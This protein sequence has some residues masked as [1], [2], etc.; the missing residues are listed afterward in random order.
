MGGTSDKSELDEYGV[1]VKNNVHLG[2][3]KK[4]EK[5]PPS[6]H[7]AAAVDDNDFLENAMISKTIANEISKLDDIPLQQMTPL[8]TDNLGSFLEQS[9]QSDLLPP[10]GIN[11]AQDDTNPASLV[12]DT[13][14][15]SI[16]D[17][18]DGEI[19]LASFMS[20]TP[21]G[22]VDLSAFMDSFPSSAT[23]QGIADGDVDL[24]A[25]M[26]SS[27]ASS[28][29]GEVDLSAFMGS[30]PTS[31]V[32][33]DVDLS[34]FLGGGNGDVDLSSFMGD[35]S[36]STPKEEQ[37]QFQDEQPLDL[38]LVFEESP[39]E[40]QDENA[41]TPAVSTAD[42]TNSRLDDYQ[43]LLGGF[44]QDMPQI[45]PQVESSAAS[46]GEE[47]ID[48]SAFGFDDSPDAL[49]SAGDAPK[50]KKAETVIDY[51]MNVDIEEEEESEK[52]KV[53]AQDDGAS[54]DDDE[55]KVDISQDSETPE[56][57]N[58]EADFSSPDDSFDLDAIFSNIEDESGNMVSFFLDENS[59]KKKTSNDVPTEMPKRNDSQTASATP[60]SKEEPKEDHLPDMIATAAFLQATAEAA[61]ALE[62]GEKDKE[63]L[64]IDET[65]S[66]SPV[67]KAET[68]DHP[69]VDMAEI[70]KPE[71]LNLAEDNLTSTQN[72]TEESPIT[73]EA[74]DLTPT[75]QSTQ[76]SVSPVQPIQSMEDEGFAEGKDFLKEAGLLDDD[77]EDAA[78]TKDEATAGS[79][80]LAEEEPTIGLDD[81]QKI[82][83]EEIPTENADL[84]DIITE[85]NQETSPVESIEPIGPVEIDEV[86]ETLQEEETEYEIPSLDAKELESLEALD[87]AVEDET[88]ET[89][90][91][92]GAQ[93]IEPPTEMIEKAEAADDSENEE[94][95]TEAQKE[96][97]QGIT[98]ND[99]ADKILPAKTLTEVAAQERPLTLQAD[100]LASF[101]EPVPVLSEAALDMA[102][103]SAHEE[104]DDTAEPTV[105]QFNEEEKIHLDTED[106][107]ELLQESKEKSESDNEVPRG[108]V[109]EPVLGEREGRELVTEEKTIEGSEQ[110]IENDEVET[111][112]DEEKKKADELDV[113]A[114][115]DKGPDYDMTGVTVTLD[116]LEKMEEI[117]I[118]E[119]EIPS[120]LPQETSS[121]EEMQEDTEKQM[122]SVFV[123]N[124]TTSSGEIEEVGAEEEEVEQK[125]KESEN[126]AIL[127]KIAQELESLKAEISGLRDEFEQL[128]KSG[129]PA[130]TPQEVES[131]PQEEGG[132]FNDDDGDDTIALSGD[133]LSNIL[134]TAEFTSQDAESL[135]KEET[136]A[137]EAPQ[138]AAES[139]TG[140]VETRDESETKSQVEE[141]AETEQPVVETA[142]EQQVPSDA[143]QD[144]VTQK[145]EV[146]PI[147]QQV[148]ETP[149]QKT[150]E[151]TTEVPESE[152]TAEEVT[153]E[154]TTEEESATQEGA[155]G[156][157]ESEAQ[158]EALTEQKADVTPQGEPAEQSIQETQ[159]IE[160]S[161]AGTA[162]ETETKQIEPEIAQETQE[163]AV[164]ATTEV[165][166]QQPP[167]PAAE[168]ENQISDVAQEASEAQVSEPT[169]EAAPEEIDKT[170][171]TEKTEKTGETV[172]TQT[173]ED[174]SSET[175]QAEPAEKESCDTTQEPNEQIAEATEA[176]KE[177]PV[178]AE[179]QEQTTEAEGESSDVE[180]ATAE[181]LVVE[182]KAEGEAQESA[183]DPSQAGEPSESDKLAEPAGEPDKQEE[184]IQETAEAVAQETTPEVQ[185]EQDAGQQDEGS[186]EKTSV[187]SE[188]DIP[189]PTLESLN[190]P[191]LSETYELSEEET[192]PLTE[193]NIE[194]LKSDVPE[195][196]DEDEDEENIETGISE[197]PV[198][199]FSNWGAKTEIVEEPVSE[200][201]VDSAAAAEA[202]EEISL[203]KPQSE[204]DVEVTKTDEAKSE[205]DVKEEVSDK[206]VV[207]QQQ[208]TSK[209]ENITA[210]LM[211][212]IK[213]VLTYM[214]RLLENLPEEKIEEFARSEQFETYKKLFVELGLA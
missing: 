146:E 113:S 71:S 151:E 203:P 12:K 143:L 138:Q 82:E 53:K 37:A 206:P 163:T 211:A 136:A 58:Q 142:S 176:V 66:V 197:Q 57:K 195:E 174:V 191:T 131:A 52:Q 42:D 21:D 62:K 144:D 184:P 38:D 67:G 133:E 22:D 178:T 148:Q 162:A 194:Y 28:P 124:E 44:A 171:E 122:Y 106:V 10:S 97:I 33:G 56:Q 25:F 204:A 115:I 86:D 84:A 210:D 155:E 185:N 123:C 154:A 36:I 128:K 187:I 85:E 125:G 156:V 20:D 198:D 116:D 11:G 27:P 135:E 141:A 72:A 64:K 108:E 54:D 129:V 63:T 75:L 134:S 32:D 24:S 61:N 6:L 50:E 153:P 166:T 95:K 213:A 2:A 145:G 117:P 16:Q 109:G 76:T 90:E 81:L 179:T 180:N 18:P 177:E 105:P 149:V 1:W 208:V 157:A 101:H 87:L 207:A 201:N 3:N 200:P 13:A 147:E 5:L 182:T 78:L 119:P 92:S 126:V 43:S 164:E 100:E 172:A 186:S 60:A 159:D 26:D 120:P 127:Q 102:V 169:Q 74:A 68:E 114:Y 96:D 168:A 31:S 165:E 30:S 173:S 29:D 214:D 150:A 91:S 112:N 80:R 35:T 41:L 51:V 140:E 104:S 193:D 212:Q 137:S 93:E 130:A 17:S 202:E 139:E 192:E 23:P 152:A 160:S 40:L 170:A 83:S 19:D 158:A 132:F 88:D 15:S 188:E 55:I 14:A 79:K 70:E 4:E 99:L 196:F 49:P 59:G 9:A 199:V 77:I 183:G 107:E 175:V 7:Q 189:S 34:A 190:L 110:K 46:S 69:A 48:L 181:E 161:S 167:E 39:F 118:V 45:T 98:E 89:I 8:Q 205:P 121:A 73:Q 65:A 103:L 47:E 111:M 209:P 94:Q